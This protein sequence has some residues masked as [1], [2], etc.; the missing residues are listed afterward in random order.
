VA[1]EKAV[2][3]AK[4][5]PNRLVLGADTV[6]ELDGRILGKPGGAKAARCMLKALSGRSHLVWTGVCLC[7][8]ATG[9]EMVEAVSSTVVFRDL[10]DAEIEAYVKTGEPRDKAGAYAIQGKGATL[11]S[12]LEGSF[13]NV[14]GLPTEWVV[15]RLRKAEGFCVDE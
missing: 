11:V 1:R 9:L 12:G 4:R 2:E 14:V 13:S 3:V 7:C 10:S 5:L 8:A 15:E 6:I